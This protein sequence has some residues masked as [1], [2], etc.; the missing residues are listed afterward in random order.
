MIGGG[1]WL[2]AREWVGGEITYK[3]KS[4][5]QMT[6]KT[7]ILIIAII[8]M[9]VS[10][11]WMHKTNYEL[12][13]IITFSASAITL[14]GLFLFPQKKEPE[15][16]KQSNPQNNTQ[17]VNVSVNMP[18]IE[19]TNTTLPSP[20]HMSKK[21]RPEEIHEL[22]KQNINILFIDDD[23]KF[24][25]VKILKDSGW[26][27]TRRVED[28]KS[29][30]D[31]AVKTTDIFFVDIHGVGKKL[32][33][34]D[35]GLDLALMLKRKYPSKKVVIYSANQRNNIFHES[36]R[37]ADFILEKNA[38]PIEFQTLVENY[39]IDIFNSKA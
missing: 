27:N 28:I 29:I 31:K 25:I 21:L 37:V 38:L 39:S 20:P 35:E 32:G 15:E 7:I 22:M 23:D 8:A 3:T 12:E 1:G 26:K 30:D 36:I 14:L 5:K 10:G 33:C 6:L 2:E 16:K 19:K 17:N 24:K 18:L 9:T 4:I 34:P 11:I 13:P